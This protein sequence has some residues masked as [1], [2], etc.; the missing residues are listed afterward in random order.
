MKKN[1]KKL[2]IAICNWNG[3]NTD[4]IDKLKERGHTLYTTIEQKDKKFLKK[5]DVLITWNEVHEY[6]NDIFLE[7]VKSMGIKTILVQHGRRGTS[8]IHPPFNEK[9]ICDVACLWSENDKKRLVGCGNPEDRIRVTGTSIFRHLKPRI[10]HEGINVVYSPEHWGDEVVENNIVAGAL[11]KMDGVNIVTKILHGEHTPD[12]YDN[13][14]ISNR[15]T[16]EHFQ[17]VADVLS[18]ADVVVAISESTFELMAQILDIP[19]VI[20]DIWIPK[21]CQGDDRYKEIKHEFSNAC[22]RVKDINKLGDAI[23]YAAKHPEHLRAERKQIA[24]DDGGI[25]IINPVDKL[26]EIIES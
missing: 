11:R 20:A 16:P 5:L 15:N 17:I 7:E 19:V 23:K 13:V 14:V 3:V 12:Q 25:D 21:A 6:G 22:V 24:I 26:I 8:R 10:P 4:L 2:N 1:K 18:T 9:L